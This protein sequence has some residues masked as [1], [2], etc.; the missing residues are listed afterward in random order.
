[1]ARTLVPLAQGCEE[2]EAITVIDLLRRAGVEVVSAGLDAQP[3]KAS[4]GVVLI[5][6]TTLDEV[7]SDSFD[8]IV[9]P[10][11]LPGADNLNRDP[12][13]HA[14][15][16]KLNRNGK[17]TA[18]ICAAPKVLASAGLLDGRRATGYPG[19][20]EKT[21]QDGIAIDSGAVVRDGNVITSRGPGTAMDFALEL[22]ELLAGGAKRREV[23][24]ALVR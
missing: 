6:D 11:G 2:L 20:L 9:L 13:I 16:E 22:I 8:M 4:R 12:R 21:G 19:V 17:Y 14:L 15:L 18:A 7:M 3:V 24:K 10:G 1:M 5:P 23:E